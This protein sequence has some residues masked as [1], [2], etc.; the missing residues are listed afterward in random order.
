[1][2][3]FKNTSWLFG[4]KNTTNSSRLFVGILGSS[5]NKIKDNEISKYLKEFNY[6]IYARSINTVKFIENIFLEEREK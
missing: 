2:K 3:Y 1:M 4:E 6:P 5:L